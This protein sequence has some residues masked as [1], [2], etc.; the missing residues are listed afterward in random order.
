MNASIQAVE[1]EM[2]PSFNEAIRAGKPV[3]AMSDSSTI[4]DGLL[5]PMVSLAYLSCTHLA[6]IRLYIKGFL[7]MLF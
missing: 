4:A 2:C 7:T 3:E 1:S 6:T 5:V